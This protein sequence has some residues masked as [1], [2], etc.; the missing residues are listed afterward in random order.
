M[1]CIGQTVYNDANASTIAASFFTTGTASGGSITDTNLQTGDLLTFQ[2]GA[3]IGPVT[4]TQD[5]NMWTFIFPTQGPGGSL[6][7]TIDITLSGF[8]AAVESVE[9]IGAGIFT[10]NPTTG[11]TITTMQLSAFGHSIIN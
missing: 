2:G 3:I 11:A 8:S 5:K 9:N 7:S 4:I 10:V 6:L 1:M